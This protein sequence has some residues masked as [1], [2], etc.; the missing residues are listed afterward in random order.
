V[1]KLPYAELVAAKVLEPGRGLESFMA[2]PN[3][4]FQG[5]DAWIDPT[6]P[7]R[8][9]IVA[10]MS[11]QYDVICFWNSSQ[12]GL[13]RYL[14]LIHR[15]GP[16]SRVVFY[17]ILNADVQGWRDVKRLVYENKITP[18]ISLELPREYDER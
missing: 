8:Q 16:Q 1:Q 5:G 2:N 15:A 3:Q 4:E 13:G 6:K 12:G 18:L 10:A 17:A 11:A 14:M 9:L 7:R